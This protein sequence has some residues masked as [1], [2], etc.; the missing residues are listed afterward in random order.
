MHYPFTVSLVLWSLWWSY[1]VCA[2]GDMSVQQLL[3]D[4]KEEVEVYAGSS[5]TMT[6]MI[7]FVVFNA[8]A[9]QWWL[10][11]KADTN[12]KCWFTGTFYDTAVMFKNQV[13]IDTYNDWLLMRG[14]E[15]PEKLEK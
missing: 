4:R 10:D 3:L 6:H 12:R 8:T 7:P 11:N 2:N 15:A 13:C 9:I 14:A 1:P 5:F